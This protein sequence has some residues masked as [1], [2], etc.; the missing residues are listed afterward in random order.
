VVARDL[1]YTAMPPIIP[2][3]TMHPAIVSSPEILAAIVTI[4]WYK[5]MFDV[6]LRGVNWQT[7]VSIQTL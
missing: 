4:P 7:R 5:P 3:G 6:A 2:V 1:R